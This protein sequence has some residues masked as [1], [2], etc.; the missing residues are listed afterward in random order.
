ML[1]A[2]LEAM[3]LL[4]QHVYCINALITN[5]VRSAY[6]VCP[7]P[8]VIGSGGPLL[9]LSKTLSVNYYAIGIIVAIFDNCNGNYQGHILYQNQISLMQ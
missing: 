2:C 7:F 5:A 6:T 9:A 1:T 4:H 8:K 3:M